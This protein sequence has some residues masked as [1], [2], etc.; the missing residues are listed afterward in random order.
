VGSKNG[1]GANGIQKRTKVNQKAFLAALC[2]TGNITRAAEAAGVA[3]RQHYNWLDNDST[4]LKRFEECIDQAADNLEAEARRRA[5][6]GVAEPVFYKGKPIG[7]VRKYSDTLLIFLLKGARPDK[8]RE[9]HQIN[10]T[11][12]VNV[13]DFFRKAAVERA[14]PILARN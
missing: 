6:E 13:V 2:E 5:V 10:S 11:I 12:T 4:Y 3:R 14:D 8:Y 9:R 7:A 1:N